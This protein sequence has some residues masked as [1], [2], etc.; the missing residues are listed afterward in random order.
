[1][2]LADYSNGGQFAFFALPLSKEFKVSN[3]KKKLYRTHADMLL[4]ESGKVKQPSKNIPV[5][6]LM[7]CLHC[8][9]ASH[10]A[11]IV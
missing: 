11:F 8:T 9:G 3:K 10:F 1:M 7:T 5:Y 2:S 6:L 4:T